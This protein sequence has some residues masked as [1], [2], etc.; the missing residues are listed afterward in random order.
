MVSMQAGDAPP[1]TQRIS[2]QQVLWA[3]KDVGQ[4]MLGKNLKSVL[5]VL[6]LGTGEEGVWLGGLWRA[7]H[8]GR[9]VVH[10]HIALQVQ[11]D[12]YDAAAHQNLLFCKSYALVSTWA[13]GIQAQF[14][15]HHRVLLRHRATWR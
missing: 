13:A 11:Q 12:M 14:H 15:M 2:G 5:D 6:G 10:K 3:F 7:P 4:L 8:C 1:S 9:C